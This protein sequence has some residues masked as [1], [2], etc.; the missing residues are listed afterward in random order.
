MVGLPPPD[1]KRWV[2]R[3]KAAVV[4]AVRS[5]TMNIEDACQYYML[6]REEFAAWERAIEAYGVPGLRSTRLQ[7]YRDAPPTRL[8][9]PR[10]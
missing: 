6:S 8:V 7:V 1:T 5:G 9:K 2:A 10:F 3:R 4:D